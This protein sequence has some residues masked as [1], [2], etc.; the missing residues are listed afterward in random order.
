MKS[1]YNLYGLFIKWK[2]YLAERSDLSRM[3]FE[4]RKLRE[5][6]VSTW[7][8]SDLLTA[9]WVQKITKHHRATKI[10]ILA[11]KGMLE[12]K[13]GSTLRIVHEK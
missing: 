1:K 4:C 12:Y 3:Q 2:G 7:L 11:N 5:K 8:Y 9:D 10:P 6:A 13:W